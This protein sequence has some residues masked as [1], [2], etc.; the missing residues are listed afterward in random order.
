MALPPPGKSGPRVAARA[1]LVTTNYRASPVPALCRDFFWVL[2][3]SLHHAPMPIAR[4]ATPRDPDR[5]AS[6]REA[7]CVGREN[8]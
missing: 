1:D 2:R 7:A 4:P 8:I 5:V 6:E 3:P